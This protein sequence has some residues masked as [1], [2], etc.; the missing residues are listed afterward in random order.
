VFTFGIQPWTAKLWVGLV[1]NDI[2][3]F[4]VNSLMIKQL[5]VSL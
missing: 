2:V 3:S 5:G 1:H 4:V